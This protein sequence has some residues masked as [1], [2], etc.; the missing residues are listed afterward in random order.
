MALSPRSQPEL[1][2][3]FSMLHRVTAVAL[4]KTAAVSGGSK[5]TKRLFTL[6]ADVCAWQWQKGALLT[7]THRAPFLFVVF[8]WCCFLSSSPYFSTN[9]RSLL[10]GKNE[11]TREIIQISDLFIIK[12]AR[13]CRRLYFQLFIIGLAYIK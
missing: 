3:R 8:F 6:K 4:Q 11:E 2:T 1:R 7:L 12:V 5:N 9:L 10:I 13:A